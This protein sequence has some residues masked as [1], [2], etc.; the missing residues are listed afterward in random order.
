MT[1][2]AGICDNG[3][4]IIG[5]DS[6]AVNGYNICSTK[7][8]KVF[9]VDE[10]IIGY[11]TSF[12]M[13]QLLQYELQIPERPNGITDEEYIIKHFIKEVRKCMQTG[14]YATI[15]N[16]RESSGEWL[17]GYRGK[18]YHIGS[19]YG[20]LENMMG[21]S[22]VGCGSNIALGA[23]FAYDGKPLFKIKTGLAAAAE[24]SAGVRAPFTILTLPPRKG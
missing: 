3:T 24:F 6:A 7:L 16:N 19:D 12:R 18:L 20:V 9:I 4:V 21:Y 23:M 1:C 8:P 5:A 17:L 13:G 2:I 10:F 15:D 11:T 22:A 14:G